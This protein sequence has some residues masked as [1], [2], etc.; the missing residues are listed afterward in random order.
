[1][2][3]NPWCYCVIWYLNAAAPA[4]CLGLERLI[5]N[6]VDLCKP[7]RER[8]KESLDES[9]ISLKASGAATTQRVSLSAVSYTRSAYAT[10]VAFHHFHYLCVHWGFRYFHLGFDGARLL[11]VHANPD[12][13]S[14]ID[15]RIGLGNRNTL[16]S[17][18][19]VLG[20]FEARC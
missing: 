5:L 8:Y 2:S 19:D 17:M 3:N 15:L 12:R 1:M 14:G 18:A 9:G 20:T 4:G 10:E 13:L 16:S 6:T 7:L 11:D